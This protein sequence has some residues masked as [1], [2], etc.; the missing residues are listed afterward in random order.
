M[1]SSDDILRMRI[2]AV[3]LL[4][5]CSSSE[6][7]LSMVG[8]RKLVCSKIRDGEIAPW[9]SVKRLENYNPLLF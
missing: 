3:Y 7:I 5:L 2:S 1:T 9:L 4:F 8:S 6:N